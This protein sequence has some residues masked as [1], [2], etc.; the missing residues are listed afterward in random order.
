MKASLL[1]WWILLCLTITST[2]VMYYG[3]V[4]YA[5]WYADITKIS[6]IIIALYVALTLY[7]GKLTVTHLKPDS[8]KSNLG[9]NLENCWFTANAM[10][11]LGMIGTVVGFLIMLGPAFKSLDIANAAS[12]T[13]VI[14]DM[15]TGMSTALTTTLVGLICSLLANAGCPIHLQ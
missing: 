8:N 14:T 13:Q 12:T 4:F 9:I 10:T 7:V 1:R 15:A 3:N 11:A 5:L 6:F 2:V